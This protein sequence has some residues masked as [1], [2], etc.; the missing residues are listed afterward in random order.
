LDLAF[1]EE[2]EAQNG[3]ERS[4][5]DVLIEWTSFS[6]VWFFVLEKKN[7][8]E[9]EIEESTDCCCCYFFGTCKNGVRL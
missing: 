1:S 4:R 7:L 5:W 3:G 9:K 6:S 8:L 2:E